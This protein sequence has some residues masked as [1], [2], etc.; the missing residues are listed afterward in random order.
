MKSTLFADFLE[1]KLKGRPFGSRDT[2]FVISSLSLLK[3]MFRADSQEGLHLVSCI[4]EKLRVIGW[5]LNCALDVGAKL[6]NEEESHAYAA[7]GPM[8]L[9]I[10]ERLSDLAMQSNNSKIHG[11]I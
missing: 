5:Q 2:G 11:V 3:A 4:V 1:H 6:I 8:L 7:D 10:R 9:F